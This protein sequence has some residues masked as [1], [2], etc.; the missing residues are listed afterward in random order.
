MLDGGCSIYLHDAASAISYKLPPSYEPPNWMEHRYSQEAWLKRALENHPWRTRNVAEAD[1]I[2]LAAQF[3]KICTAR[4]SYAARFL[5]H[6]HLNDTLL[7]NGRATGLGLMA[8]RGN[9]GCRA[10]TPPKLLVMGNTECTPPWEGWGGQFMPPSRLPADYLVAADRRFRRVDMR[11]RSLVMPAVLTRP[12]WLV[13]GGER[14]TPPPAIRA[15]LSHNWDQRRLLFFPGH[16]PKL[17]VSRRRFDIWNQLRSHPLVTST[18]HTL[19]CTVG[20]YSVCG[21][22]RRME[23]EYRTFCL[24]ACERIARSGPQA[25]RAGTFARQGGLI[26]AAKDVRHL[27]RHCSSYRGVGFRDESFRAHLQRDSRFLSHDEYLAEAFTHRFCLAVPGDFMSASPK[28]TEFV[29]VG[30]A[31]G[32]IPVLVVPKDA[33]MILPHSHMLDY[34]DFAYLVRSTGNMHAVLARL[35]NVTAAEAAAKHAAL[36][37]VRDFFV[38]REPDRGPSAADHVLKGICSL[39]RQQQSNLSASLLP[40]SLVYDGGA[41]TGSMRAAGERCLLS[42]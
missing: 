32:C 20:S 23:A 31:G 4:K 21:S 22:P 6:V 26:C 41:G 10:R 11:A 35:E 34:C 3:S 28:I 38:W 17:Y 12:R 13:D 37:R 8:S 5:W 2:L 40:Q 29:A 27:Q 30:A 16:I 9:A 14:G 24:S 36:R 39:V 25:A 1:V 33:S 15:L 42:L 19:N 7:C 18:S